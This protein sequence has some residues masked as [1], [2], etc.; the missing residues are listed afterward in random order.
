MTMGSPVLFHPFFPSTF[1]SDNYCPVHGLSRLVSH[2]LVQPCPRKPETTRLGPRPQ[3]I[4]KY[5][6]CSWNSDLEHLGWDHGSEPLAAPMQRIFVDSCAWSLLQGWRADLSIWQNLDPWETPL[7]W[8]P[9]TILTLQTHSVLA[10]PNSW[11]VSGLQV[12][13]I[14][15]K[16]VVIILWWYTV[17]LLW[18]FLAWW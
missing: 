2:L 9:W 15:M 12:A 6:R 13:P 14:K 3:K 11:F 4:L 18:C 17:N 10:Q 1:T 16:C 8:V 5:W 7:V